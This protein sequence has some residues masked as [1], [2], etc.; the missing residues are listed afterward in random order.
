[1]VKD[2]PHFAGR[3]TVAQADQFALYPAVSRGRVSGRDPEHQV[4][5]LPRNGRPSCSRAGVGPVP[6]DQLSVPAEQGRRG[7]DER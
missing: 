5:D 2:L 1:M 3:N 4:T 7:D 6:G